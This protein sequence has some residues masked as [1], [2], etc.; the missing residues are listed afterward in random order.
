[1]KF[2]YGAQSMK[3]LDYNEPNSRLGVTT[4][5]IGVSIAALSVSKTAERY[6]QMLKAWASKKVYYPLLC[7]SVRAQISLMVSKIDFF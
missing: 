4:V 1:M 5:T 2:T 3:D 6:Q 7:L